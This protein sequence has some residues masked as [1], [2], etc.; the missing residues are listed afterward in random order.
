MWSVGV[1]IYTVLVGY[2]PILEQDQQVQ[3][4]KICAAEY[5][6]FEEDWK[7]ISDAAKDLIRNLLVVD[8]SRRLTASQALQHPWITGVN[9]NMN[10]NM[11]MNMNMNANVNTVGNMNMNMN[12][13][14][15]TN[16]NANTAVTTKINRNV[17]DHGGHLTAI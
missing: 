4:R 17:V 15:N 14:A 1:V 12:M 3:C 6:F 13:G 7:R 11:D 5:D 16:T 10:M 8:P 2:P 9:G